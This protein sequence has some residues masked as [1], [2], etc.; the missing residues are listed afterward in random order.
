MRVGPG[1]AFRVEQTAAAAPP[2]RRSHAIDGGKK[3][4]KRNASSA[5]LV[6][7]D[8]AW[9][10]FSMADDGEVIAYDFEIVFDLKSVAIAHPRFVRVD[11]NEPGHKNEVERDMR[12]HL[13]PGHD[14][15][16]SRNQSR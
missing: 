8:Q 16:P 15:G 1:S 13:H 3:D 11:C 4:F 6:R 12:C 2:T 14:G 5:R 10:H 7:D 9:V